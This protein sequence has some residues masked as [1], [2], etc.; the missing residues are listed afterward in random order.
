MVPVACSLIYISSDSFE[1]LKGQVEIIFTHLATHLHCLFF[2]FFYPC[3]AFHCLLNMVVI[4]ELSC[5]L[6]SAAKPSFSVGAGSSV[7]K[8]IFSIF[9]FKGYYLLLSS[10]HT[11]NSVL[12]IQ[13]PFFEVLA[14][15][16]TISI[17]QQ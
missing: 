6:S 16:D 15:K 13:D 14:P 5:F 2:F 9:R 17:W 1:D 3:T 4:T 10:R 11:A 8:G 7:S 12:L